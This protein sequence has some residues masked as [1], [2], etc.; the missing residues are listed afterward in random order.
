MVKNAKDSKTA[1]TNTDFRTESPARKNS[2]QRS[3]RGRSFSPPTSNRTSTYETFPDSQHGQMQSQRSNPHI[4]H[5]NISQGR[6]V[7]GNHYNDKHY[8]PKG[9]QEPIRKSF[10]SEQITGLDRFRKEHTFSSGSSSSKSCLFKITFVLILI[11]F[12]GSSVR[13][14][15]NWRDLR[16][17]IPVP[18]YDSKLKIRTKNANNAGKTKGPMTIPYYPP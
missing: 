5:A 18:I 12:E 4:N 3:Q 17:G 15:G 6:F 7:S 1:A 9:E 8:L 14:S 16:S 11:N 2:R 13:Q 10:S